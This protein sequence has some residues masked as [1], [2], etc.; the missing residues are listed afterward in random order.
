MLSIFTFFAFYFIVQS[1]YCERRIVN[2]TRALGEPKFLAYFIKAPH[3][4]K[5]YVGWICGG[6]IIHPWYI[7]TSAVCID[8]VR[9][10]FAIVGYNKYVKTEDMDKDDCTK[11]TKKRIIARAYQRDI[12]RTLSQKNWNSRD[13][14][15]AKVESPYDFRDPVYTRHCSYMPG[16]IKVNFNRDFEMPGTEVITYGWGHKNFIRQEGDLKDHNAKFVNYASTIVIDKEL[17]KK[18]L[19]GHSDIQL[20]VEYFLIC[21]SGEGALDEGGKMNN[22][23]VTPKTFNGSTPGIYQS[24]LSLDN[25]VTHKTNHTDFTNL[26]RH[27]PC[28]NDHGGP[29]VTWIGGREYV[30]GIASGFQVN[31]KMQCVAPY[32][33][34]S[35]FSNGEFIYC[36]LRNTR[37]S[38]LCD[39]QPER[40]GYEIVE[41]EINWNI[42]IARSTHLEDMTPVVDN[43]KVKKTNKNS[44]PWKDAGYFLQLR[45]TNHSDDKP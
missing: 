1:T 13:I 44:E 18:M 17:C 24:V 16:S 38:T 4:P 42:N 30:I 23:P 28:Q 19:V 2:G 21:T 41:E 20:N 10:V 45:S 3:S 37:R 29:L 12:N 35:T 5:N 36:L 14:S 22:G 8:D 34:T 31:K 33:Y 7:L 39:V 6:A 9:H 40:K 11:R 43:S 15:L 32:L 26:R 27:G 25:L